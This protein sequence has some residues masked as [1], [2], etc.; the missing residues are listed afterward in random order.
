[1]KNISIEILIFY[2]GIIVSAEN[3]EQQNPVFMG[4]PSRPLILGRPAFYPKGKKANRSSSLYK[5]NNVSEGMAERVPIEEEE[6]DL[7][8]RLKASPIT[9]S[10][11]RQ[12]KE[13]LWQYLCSCLCA[14]VNDD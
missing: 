7:D 2:L 13:S 6:V 14:R 5:V 9:T 12:S 4:V 3:I 1:M 11:G 8:F 10:P